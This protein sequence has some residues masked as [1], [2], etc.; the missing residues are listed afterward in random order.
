MATGIYNSFWNDALKGRLTPS[1]TI[2]GM[3][4]GPSYV[5]NKDAHDTRASLTAE[6]SGTGY[7]AGGFSVTQAITQDLNLDRTILT[8]GAISAV[9]TTIQNVRYVV[10]Y[11]SNGGAATGDY[12]ISCKD[13]DSNYSTTNQPINISAGLIIISNPN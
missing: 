12:L 2:K 1:S 13:F 4:L 3:L 6:V 10:Y 5:F 11:I 9:G 8:L 7:T